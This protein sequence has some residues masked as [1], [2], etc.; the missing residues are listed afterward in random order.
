[1]VPL[2]EKKAWIAPNQI[3]CARN[4]QNANAATRN[5]A[6]P[7]ALRCGMA[8]ADAVTECGTRGVLSQRNSV[9]DQNVS[10]ILRQLKNS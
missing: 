5:V 4:R 2:V 6:I 8:G 1:M 7:D 10:W 9:R 3:D